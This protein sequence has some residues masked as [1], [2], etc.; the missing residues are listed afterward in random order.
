M[1]KTVVITGA[2]RGIGFD[3]ALQIC[4][5]GHRVI[6]IAR[7]TAGLESLYNAASSARSS[8]NLVV[9]PAN[10]AN[11]QHRDELTN[12]INQLT[13]AVDVL[14][15]NAGALVNKPFAEITLEELHQVYD[16]NVFAPFT[17]T[18]K[19]LPLLLKS[20][21]GHIV[22]I[23]SVGGVNGTSKFGGLSVYSSSKG[24]IGILSEVLAEEFKETRI[25]VNCLALG[26]A[27]TEMLDQAFPGYEAPLTSSEM[28]EY[29]AWFA[30]NGQR[31]F[32]G[33]VI[34]V[35]LTTP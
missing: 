7:S 24:A 13:N 1:S 3:T 34:Q 22:N 6:A 28:A 19:L 29:I 21:T 4:K 23:G 8:A 11:A 35:A 31:F 30:L 26:A 12:R 33:K 9:I 20:S 27:K 16:V 5:A 32:N 18:Q 15:N 10:I 2:S 14:I 25:K 17:L